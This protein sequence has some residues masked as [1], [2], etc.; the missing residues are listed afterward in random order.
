MQTPLI[1]LFW[2]RPF[3]KYGPMYIACHGVVGIH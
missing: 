3:G 2:Y 1:E